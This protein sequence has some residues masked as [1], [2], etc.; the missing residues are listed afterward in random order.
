[1]PALI[2]QLLN[3]EDIRAGKGLTPAQQLFISYS[4]TVDSKVSLRASGPSITAKMS[5]STTK[6]MASTRV[7]IK[8]GPG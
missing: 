1:M 5:C 7:P 3:E 8:C 4:D 2:N 6:A